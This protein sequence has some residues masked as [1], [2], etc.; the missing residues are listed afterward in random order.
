MAAGR[1]STGIETEQNI[2]KENVVL[3]KVV[4]LYIAMM[5]SNNTSQL[6]KSYVSIIHD[7]HWV[8]ACVTAMQMQQSQYWLLLWSVVNVVMPLHVAKCDR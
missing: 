2:S 5:L 3:K 4:V 1:A 6:N 7:Q 8:A